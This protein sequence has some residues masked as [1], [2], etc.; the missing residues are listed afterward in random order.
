M[1]ANASMN[2]AWV[3]AGGRLPLTRLRGNPAIFS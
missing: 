1:A 2:V 3:R